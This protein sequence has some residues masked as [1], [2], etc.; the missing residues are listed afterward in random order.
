MFLQNKSD[1]LFYHAFVIFYFRHLF[2]DL[3]QILV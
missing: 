3:I 1:F 2:P